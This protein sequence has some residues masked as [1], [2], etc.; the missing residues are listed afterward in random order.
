MDPSD[1]VVSILEHLLMWPGALTPFLFKENVL[2][3]CPFNE[4]HMNFDDKVTSYHKASVI[5]L[6]ETRKLFHQGSGLGLSGAKPLRGEMLVN[7]G[8]NQYPWPI[9]GDCPMGCGYSL[10]RTSFSSLDGKGHGPQYFVLVLDRKATLYENM[11]IPTQTGQFKYDDL[12]YMFYVELPS[13]MVI[14]FDEKPNTYQLKGYIRYIAHGLQPDLGAPGLSGHYTAYIRKG[15]QRYL[16]DDIG[17]PI[18]TISEGEMRRMSHHHLVSFWEHKDHASKNM[19]GGR[20]RK[21]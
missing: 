11:H 10:T 18:R 19:S 12:G 16:C 3:V 2:E 21:Q 1:L 8:F 15:D 6:Y 13:E 17:A 5:K 9:F 20:S 4:D 7:L 14:Q